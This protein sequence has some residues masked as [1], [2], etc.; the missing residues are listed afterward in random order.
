MHRELDEDLPV[1]RDHCVFRDHLVRVPSP[2]QLLYMIE[3]SHPIQPN[4]EDYLH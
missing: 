2:A 4:V 1:R 3:I